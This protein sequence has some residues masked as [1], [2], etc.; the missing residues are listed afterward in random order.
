MSMPLPFP[1]RAGRTH[2][3]CGLG[4]TSFACAVAAT[5]SGPVIWVSERHRRDGLNPRGLLSFFDPARLL[6]ARGKDQTDTLAVMEEAL[7]DGSAP[8]VIGETP[9]AISLTEGRRLQ[10]AAKQGEATGLC[11]ISPQGG[12]NAAETRWQAMPIFERDLREGVDAPRLRWRQI[13]NKSGPC[14]AW[15]VRWNARDRGPEILSVTDCAPEP[16]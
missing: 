1:L 8:L 10:L 16:G 13:K 15:E 9:K 5:T 12:S 3:V 2:E 14:R 4:A 11:L 6:I 7:R